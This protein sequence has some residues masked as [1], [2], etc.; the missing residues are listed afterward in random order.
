MLS[1]KNVTQFIDN[2]HNKHD[3]TYTLLTFQYLIP[4]LENEN[5]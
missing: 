2:N 4:L 3:A 1:V 5:N